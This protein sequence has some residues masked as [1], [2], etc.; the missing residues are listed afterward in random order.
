MHLSRMKQKLKTGFS[1]PSSWRCPKK[2]QRMGYVLTWQSAGIW[3]WARRSWWS[4][5]WWASCAAPAVGRFDLKGGQC[6]VRRQGMADRTDKRKQAVI[7]TSK[8]RRAPKSILS[9]YVLKI[10]NSYA[11]PQKMI[12]LRI[13]LYACL[14]SRKWHRDTKVGIFIFWIPRTFITTKMKRVEEKKPT[15]HIHACRGHR[16]ADTTCTFS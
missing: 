13:S 2:G 16:F 12:I 11:G 1:K 15:F 8:A 4:W 6:S 5:A 14:A 9:R 3:I 7:T 10:A